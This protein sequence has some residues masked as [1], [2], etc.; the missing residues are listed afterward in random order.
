MQSFTLAG[1]TGIVPRYRSPSVWL[2]FF[3]SS[4]EPFFE[5]FRRAAGGTRVGL[6][7]AGDRNVDQDRVVPYFHDT[8]PGYSRPVFGKNH[9]GQR[10]RGHK[11]RGDPSAVRVYLEIGHLSDPVA[12]ADVHHVLFSEIASSTSHI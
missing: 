11:D 12:A 4:S 10:I 2:C 5:A 9:T 8:L 6:R 3:L 7:S 1:L